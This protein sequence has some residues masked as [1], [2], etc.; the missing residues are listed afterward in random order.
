MI[1][2]CPESRAS[3]AAVANA[4]YVE[5][6]FGGI[7]GSVG[8]EHVARDPMVNPSTTIPGDGFTCDVATGLGGAV[9][10]SAAPV[11]EQPTT[12]N[13]ATRMS[14]LDRNVRVKKTFLDLINS[15]LRQNRHGGS[16]GLYTAGCKPN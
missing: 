12:L 1:A 4:G 10:T 13:V 5:Q 6:L 3:S 7:V 16:R 9:A 8:S 14:I 2:A 15:R 11:L